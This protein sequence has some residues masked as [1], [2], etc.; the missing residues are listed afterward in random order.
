MATATLTYDL[1]D[2]G[3]IEA[4]KRA[5]KSLDMAIALYDMDQYLR[6]QTKYAPDSMPPEVYDAL[7]KTRDKLHEIMS[8]RS[9]YLDVLIS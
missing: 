7:D 8:E 2:H 6:S 5:I 9:I 4:H 3:D 1:N